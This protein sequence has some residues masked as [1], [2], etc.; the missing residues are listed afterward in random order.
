[1]LAVKAN[2]QYTITDAEADGYQAQG[3]DILDDDGKV[4]KLGTGKTVTYS[5]YQSVVEENT[6]LKAELEQLKAEKPAK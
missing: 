4:I 6:A 1:M 5:K 2:R 3:Y